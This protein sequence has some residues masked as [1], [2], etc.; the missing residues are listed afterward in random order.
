MWDMTGTL[1]VRMGLHTGVAEVHLDDVK[2]GQYASGLT[3]S[4]AQRIMSAGYG[5]QI[6]VS[7]TTYELLRGLLPDLELQPAERVTRAITAVDFSCCLTRRKQ[8]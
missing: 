2:A 8:L 1:R 6:L 3:L 5:G 4:R 7:S